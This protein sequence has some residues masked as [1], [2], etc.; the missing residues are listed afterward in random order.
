VDRAGRRRPLSVSGEGRVYYPRLSPDGRR[1]AL[2]VGGTSFN[3]GDIWL[4]DISTGG[5]TRLTSDNGSYRQQWSRDGKRILFLNGIG[6]ATRLIARPWDGSG[7]D[8]VVLALPGLAE[9]SE[10]PPGGWSAI[11]TFAPRDIYL[12][13]ADSLATGRKVQFVVSPASETQIVMSPDGRWLAY[14]SDETGQEEIYVRPV[15]GPGPRVLVSLGGGRDPAWSHD[16]TTLYYRGDGWLRA[17][18]VS[19]RGEFSVVRR[20]SLFSDPSLNEIE[21][22]SYS[23]TPTGEFIIVSGLQGD[24]PLRLEVVANWPSLLVP[25]R[26]PN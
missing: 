6:Q 14:S 7:T 13:P 24:V 11:R 25:A 1:V 12:V 15:P 23:P 16:G 21:S 20:D 18:R 10:G 2:R 5:M 19:T 8:S 22:R 9:F 26:S 17:A 3:T 4:L